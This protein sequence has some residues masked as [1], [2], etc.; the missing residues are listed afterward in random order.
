[1]IPIRRSDTI[2]VLTALNFECQAVRNHL[3][4]VTTRQH[5]AGTL[6]EVG[7]LAGS[8]RPIAVATLGSGN[9][10][11]AVL[12]ERAVNL[13]Q[14]A[15]LLFV[16]VAGAVK[17]GVAL[18]DIVVGTR[19]Y[20]IHGG[21]D[22]R[23]GFLARPRCWEASHELEQ[24]AR[25]VV[26]AGGWSVPIAGSGVVEP[27]AVHF[28]PIAAGEVVLDTRRS[29]LARQLHRHYNDAVAIE[30]ESA[31]FAAAGHLNRSIEILTIR[32]IS[33]TADGTKHQADR[34][35]WQPVAA[36]HAAAFAME[37]VRR[38]PQVGNRRWATA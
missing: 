36:A 20:A 2:V 33:D 24:V 37:L 14:P 34:T 22:E 13:F 16:G 1:M 5:P 21:R 6:F 38:L 25:H 26:R 7:M 30:M 29:G 8:P 17:D 15:G 19:V 28:G 9:Q 31:G 23:G 27:P 3:T 35:G 18:G 10:A 4:D 12:T 32:G 11:A